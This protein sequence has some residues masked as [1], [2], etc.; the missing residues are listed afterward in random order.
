MSLSLPSLPAART[1]RAKA[2][3]A[4]TALAALG[5]AF[6][7]LSAHCQEMQ[8]ELADWTEGRTFALGVLPDGP[9]IAVRKQG[10]R[11]VFLGRGD[12]GAP[13]QVLFKNVDVAL[14]V[15]CGLLSSHQAFAEHRMVVYGPLDETVQAN[16]AMAIVVKYL[17]PAPMLRTLFKRPPTFSRAELALKARLY[18]TIGPALARRLAP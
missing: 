2:A 11:L 9:T 17:F 12:R 1:H 8:R 6:E 14:L 4:A 5:V 7:I 13:L 3:V 10:E 15:L 18:L 16:R